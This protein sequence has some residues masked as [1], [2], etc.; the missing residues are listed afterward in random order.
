MASLK[1]RFSNGWDQNQTTMDHPKSEHVRYSSPYCKKINRDGKKCFF[2]TFQTVDFI[3][4]AFRC[5]SFD[6]ILE[7]IKLRDRLSSSQH[8]TSLTVERMLLDLLVETSLHAQ[9][10]QMMS[11]LEIDPGSQVK[12]LN[13]LVTGLQ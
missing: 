11:Y 4:S 6:K 7:F 2:F 3:I 9:T 13:D 5:G 1:V 8:Y 10:V 12:K